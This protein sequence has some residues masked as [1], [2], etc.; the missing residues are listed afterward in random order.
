MTLA[1]RCCIDRLTG[2]LAASG[3]RSREVDRDICDASAPSVVLKRG[4]WFSRQVFRV[5]I[6]RLSSSIH[7]KSIVG[8]LTTN[9]GKTMAAKLTLVPQSDLDVPEHLLQE[10]LM[11]MERSGFARNLDTAR[12]DF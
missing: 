3:G 10:A 12:G 11:E 4:N 6:R 8:T 1:A 9:E 2:K 7:R 5:R